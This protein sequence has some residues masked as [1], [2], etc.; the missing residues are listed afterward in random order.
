MHFLTGNASLSLVPSTGALNH[1]H[2]FWIGTEAD[3]LPII[4]SRCHV[5]PRW[6]R[7]AKASHEAT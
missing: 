3:R 7:L 4:P 1:G 5:G 2:E 6:E